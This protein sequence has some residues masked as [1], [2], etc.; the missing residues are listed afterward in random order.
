MKSKDPMNG[1]RQAAPIKSPSCTTHKQR[2]AAMRS[3][4]PI[5]LPSRTPIFS[6]KMS[7]LLN[8][9]YKEMQR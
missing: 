5:V 3:Q 4:S 1:G 6:G 7:F 8:A 2:V 9:Y